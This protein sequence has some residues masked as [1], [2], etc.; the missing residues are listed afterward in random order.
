MAN[1]YF[2]LVAVI[3]A[4]AVF[5]LYFGMQQ[6]TGNVTASFDGLTQGTLNIAFV[7]SK[8][9]QPIAVK[10][11]LYL[12]TNLTTPVLSGIDD[13]GTLNFTLDPN[14]YKLVAQPLPDITYKLYT[15]PTLLVVAGYT[16]NITIKSLYK[17]IYVQ[18]NILDSVTNAPLKGAYVTLTYVATG[19]KTKMTTGPLGKINFPSAG[20]L[21]IDASKQYTLDVTRL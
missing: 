8:T 7:D 6:T 16:K 17:K 13:D 3:V 15:L 1:N 19:K 5:G 4:I 21:T 14:T 2:F 12:T 18:A 10:Y 20:G 9:S 11:D